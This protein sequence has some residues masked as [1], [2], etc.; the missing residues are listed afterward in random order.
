[1]T[2]RNV[3]GTEINH[4]PREPGFALEAPERTVDPDG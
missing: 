2:K 4:M 3:S 1:V